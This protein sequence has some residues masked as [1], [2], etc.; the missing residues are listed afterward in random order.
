M[1]RFFE[2]WMQKAYSKWTRDS[3]MALTWYWGRNQKPS[4]TDIFGMNL[5]CENK[6]PSIWPCSLGRLGGHCL[7]ESNTEYTDERA[8]VSLRSLVWSVNQGKSRR[9]FCGT[10]IPNKSIGIT[11]AW[12]LQKSRS[13]VTAFSQQ[14][15][16]ICHYPN[17]QQSQSGN[18]ITL[19][20]RLITKS[21]KDETDVCPKHIV[22][23]E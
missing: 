3:E 8:L 9:C 22:C 14:R 7:Q 6:E 11:G 5:L 16:S 18:Q 12:G 13:P 23:L 21:S 2:A 1:R 20:C 19:A 4:G 10:R 15:Q 17:E